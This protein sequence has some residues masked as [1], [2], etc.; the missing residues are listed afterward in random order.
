M[1]CFCESPVCPRQH[2]GD[3][4]EVKAAATHGDGVSR[5]ARGARH[6]VRRALG[7]QPA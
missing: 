2:V 6:L 7:Y 4:V 5:L 1:L 3:R